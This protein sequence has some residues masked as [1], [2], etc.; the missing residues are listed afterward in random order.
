MTQIN[1]RGEGATEKNRKRGGENI[2]G[3]EGYFCLR[4]DIMRSRP[5]CCDVTPTKSIAVLCLTSGKEGGR[6]VDRLWK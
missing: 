4:N 2:K 6:E 3:G 5:P 1:K